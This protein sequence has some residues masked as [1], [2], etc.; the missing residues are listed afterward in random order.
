MAAPWPRLQEP[1]GRLGDYTDAL[2]G[3]FGE[4]AGRATATR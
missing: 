2:P 4:H 1:S 3:A